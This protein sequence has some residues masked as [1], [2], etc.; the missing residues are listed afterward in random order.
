MKICIDARS[1]GY[2]G[3]LNYSSCLLRALLET[4]DNNE[5]IVL[6]TSRDTAWNLDGAREIVIPSNNPV[7]WTIWSNT[8]LPEILN[9][10]GVDV[11]HSFKHISLFRSNIRKVISFHSSRFYLHPEHYKF[12][13]YAYW[14]MLSPIAARRYDAVIVVSK[15][16]KYNFSKNI[17]VPS[18]KFHVTNLASDSRFRLV[19][20]R[21]LLLDIKQKYHLPDRFLLFVGRIDP[22][23]NLETAIRAYHLARNNLATDYKF[24]IVGKKTSFYQK[25]AGIIKNLNLVNDVLFTGPIFEDLPYVYNLAD[26]FIFPSHYEAFP[27]VPLEAM[28]CGVPVVASNAGGLPEVVGDAAMMAQP[29][30]VHAFAKGLTDILSSRELHDEMIKKG[31]ERIKLFSWSRCARKTVAVYEEVVQ[32]R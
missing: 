26:A 13:D 1:P 6:R 24:V 7:N 30:D 15:A 12:A 11:Y 29:D 17:N 16:E 10:E 18:S 32:G 28:A 8:K 31:L 19:N 9:R 5:Y 23:K 4:D 14:R 22:V 20:D 27:A 2:S 21:K 3:I 25:I